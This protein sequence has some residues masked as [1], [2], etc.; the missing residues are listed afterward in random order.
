MSFPVYSTAALF[1]RLQALLDAGYPVG[2]TAAN[3]H[4]YK[5]DVTPDANMTPATFEEADFD[6][7]PALD[8][9]MGAISLNDQ[10]IV[11]SRSNSLEWTAPEGE[12]TQTV[13]GIYITNSANTVIIAAQRF[14]VPQVMGGAYATAV[15]GVWRVSE[16]LSSYGW[17]DTE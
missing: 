16:P 13:Y 15:A 9:V 5:N 6:G 11:V 12:P 10:G 8:V 2:V 4:L 1:T 14:D 3:I 7:A 17:I